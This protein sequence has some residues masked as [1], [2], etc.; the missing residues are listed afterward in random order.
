MRRKTSYSLTLKNGL[1]DPV[2]AFLAEE[3]FVYLFPQL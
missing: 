2:R 1:E 3:F